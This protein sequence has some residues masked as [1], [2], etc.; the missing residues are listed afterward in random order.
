MCRA[1]RI[2]CAAPGRTRLAALKRASVAAAWELVGGATTPEDVAAQAE[3]WAADVLVI[4]AGLGAAAVHSARS[5]RPGLQVVS[6]GGPLDGADEVAETLDQV[7]EAVL[8][9][10][11]PGGPVRG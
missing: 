4:D 1:L 5:V 7:R 11:R 6:V 9:I 8:G 3:W 2:L 10:P